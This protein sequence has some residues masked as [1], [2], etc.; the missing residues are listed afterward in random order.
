MSKKAVH[1]AAGI[2]VRNELIF[3]TKRAD[4]AHQGGKWEFPGG[5]V[6]V[7]ESVNDA[8]SRE[9]NE[10][11]GITAIQSTPFINIEHDYLDKKVTLDFYLV[12]EFAGEPAGCEGQQSQWVAVNTLATLD[13]PAANQPVIEKLMA[14]G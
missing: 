1:V 11:V 8:L 5:K 7:G 14:G 12:S 9:L 3:L 10:E 6:E 2:I 13:F 4:N